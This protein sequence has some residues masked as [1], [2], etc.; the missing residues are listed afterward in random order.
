MK[1][2]L[3]IDVGQQDD[4]DGVVDRLEQF[5]SAATR[6][7]MALVLG[8]G[9]GPQYRRQLG[10]RLRRPRSTLRVGRKTS[11]PVRS[12]KRSTEGRIRDD[13][14]SFG[15]APIRRRDLG[16]DARAGAVVPAGFV[17]RKRNQTRAAH[18][19]ST[20]R[21]ERSMNRFG[22]RTERIF[23]RDR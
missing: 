14:P 8:G 20:M 23:R 13:G 3:V 4:G 18:S 17:S 5:F 1:P 12:L 6:L 7:K 10:S 21:R 22:R 9:A 16:A 2:V 11:A 15:S 19:C